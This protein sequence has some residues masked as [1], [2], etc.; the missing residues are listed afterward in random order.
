M[1]YA[2]RNIGWTPAE[3]ESMLPAEK[4][5]HIYSDKIT[6]RDVKEHRTRLLTSARTTVLV[7]GSFNQKVSDILP[8]KSSL[9]MED[10]RMREIHGA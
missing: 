1:D 5:Q 4:S 3:M 10:N 2:L 8:E 6:L 9:S 7:T